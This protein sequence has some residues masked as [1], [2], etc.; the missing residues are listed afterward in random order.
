MF[1]D[2]NITLFAQIMQWKKWEDQVLEKDYD[3][4]QGINTFQNYQ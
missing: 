2:H 1:N 3:T 4:N